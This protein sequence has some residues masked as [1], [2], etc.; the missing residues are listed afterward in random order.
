V[1]KNINF[2]CSG[3]IGILQQPY[4]FLIKKFNRSLNIFK[5]KKYNLVEENDAG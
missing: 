2:L 3:A 5:N 4:I 1:G